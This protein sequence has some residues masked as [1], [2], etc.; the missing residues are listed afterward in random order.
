MAKLDA[1]SLKRYYEQLKGSPERANMESHCQEV[2]EYI[3]PRKIDFT[4]HRTAGDKRMQRVYDPT[5]IF[6]NDLLAAGLHGMATNPASKWFTLR[7]IS[8]QAFSPD[9]EMVDL[10]EDQSVRKFLSHVEDIMWARIYEPGTNFTTALHE[11]YLDLGAFGTAVLY[12]GQRDDGGLL[13]EPRPLAECVIADNVDGRV[14]TVFRKSTYTVRQ[15]M[16]MIETDG[17]SV[18]DR[19]K[20]L[21]D[22]QR[23]DDKVTVIHGVLPRVDRE[24][25]KKGSKQMPYASI[26]FEL[27]GEHVL[28]ESGF[29]EFPYLCPRWSKYSGEV[30]GRSPGMTA[31]PDVKMLQS[32]M[33]VFLKTGQKNADPP[34]WLKDDGVVGQVRTIPGGINYWRGNPNDGVM[35]QPTSPQGLQAVAEMMDGIRARIRTAFYTDEMQFVTDKDMTATEVMARTQERMRLLGP[36][37]GRLESE[38]LG[39]MV[40]RIFGIIER[41]GLFPAAPEQL[42]NKDFTVEYVSPIATAQRQQA[43]MG[44]Q[45]VYQLL[46][47]LGPEIGAQILMKRVNPEKLVDW[48]WSL[49]NCDP[50]LL[51]DEEEQAKAGQLQQAMQALQM[52]GP[53]AQIAKDG[54]GAVKQIADAHAS[55]GIDLNQALG[56]YGQAV[57]AN[58]KAM[59]EAQSLMNGQTPPA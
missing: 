59:G 13:F 58:P 57:Q 33:L 51:Q 26:Y 17:W 19:T 32:M 40:T 27:E 41:M 11:T 12:I 56:A 55:G 50:D 46:A 49:F 23:Y 22:T 2:A 28:A 54:A 9:G 3:S 7:M 15:M 34:M 1:A 18:S 24:P 35:L 20:G 21:Y 31:L 44:I 43:A 39:P 25:G 53:M 52:G 8:G 4:G 10:N 30:Y 36:L 42:E 5:G 6:S 48:A 47:P 37:M 38:L 16:Q 29:P 14:D 45:Q